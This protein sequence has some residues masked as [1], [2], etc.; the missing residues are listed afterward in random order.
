MALQ[1]SR[2]LAGVNNNAG[3]AP[4]GAFDENDVNMAEHFVAGFDGVAEAAGGVAA[5]VGGVA[6]EVAGGVAA[7]DGAVAD[8]A[9]D[10]R[11]VAVVVGADAA[12]GVAVDAGAVA[13]EAAGHVGDNVPAVD[14]P[15]VPVAAVTV[16]ANAVPE[17]AVGIA[18]MDG[19]VADV[20]EHARQVAVVVGAEAAGPVAVDAGPVAVEAA[21]NIGD[22]VPAVDVAAALAADA[23][24][25]AA[26]WLFL[27]NN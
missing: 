25:A 17:V 10:A 16:V 14:E 2:L 27:I 15:A 8:V 24:Y 12:G 21:G 1:L 3:P 22:N 11:P 18:A 19:A 6:A 5:V 23:A 4:P 20:A 9:E 26:G 7:M 13:A